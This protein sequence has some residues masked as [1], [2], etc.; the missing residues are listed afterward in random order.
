MGVVRVSTRD[1]YKVSPLLG[2]CVQL[3]SRRLFTSSSSSSIIARFTWR[4]SFPATSCPQ[5]IHTRTCSQQRLRL[6]P[7]PGNLLRYRSE[8]MAGLLRKARSTTAPKRSQKRNTSGTITEAKTFPILGREQDSRFAT[9]FSE[10]TVSD[11]ECNGSAGLT[12]A[13]TAVEPQNHSSTVRQRSFIQLHKRLTRK[14]STFSLRTRNRQAFTKVG[15][16]QPQFGVDEIQDEHPQH[17]QLLEK[18]PVTLSI[19]D[20][21]NLEPSEPLLNSEVPSDA[22][23]TVLYRVPTNSSVRTTDTAIQVARSISLNKPPPARLQQTGSFSRSSSS[24]LDKGF[25]DNRTF[26]TTDPN[27]RGHP[28]TRTQDSGRLLDHH[29]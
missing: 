7:A 10:K 20:A 21:S 3:Q 23:G 11:H 5:Q 14:A 19:E 26:K 15:A 6:V 16:A 12:T 29:V 8:H 9:P 17:K 24:P 28:S 27:S 25:A 13:S 18:R 4:A 2:I 22:A 1:E